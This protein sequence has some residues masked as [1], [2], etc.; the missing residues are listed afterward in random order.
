MKMSRGA[1]RALRSDLSHAA[2]AKA[3][4]IGSVGGYKSQSRNPERKSHGLAV[5]KF[6]PSKSQH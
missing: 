6:I 4:K 1:P 5:K 2:R 3:Q